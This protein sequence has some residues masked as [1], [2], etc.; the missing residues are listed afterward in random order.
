LN[1]KEIEQRDR[2]DHKEELGGMSFYNFLA[3]FA[4]FLFN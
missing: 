4:S 3:F 2:Q 1:I